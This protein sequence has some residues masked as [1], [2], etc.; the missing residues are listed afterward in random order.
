MLFRS[1][2]TYI[3]YP[4]HFIGK[5]KDLD[6]FLR[7]HEGLSFSGVLASLSPKLRKIKVYELFQVHGRALCGMPD[8]LYQHGFKNVSAMLLV[9]SQFDC[10]DYNSI[11][12]G[13]EK[14]FILRC[15]PRGPAFIVEHQPILAKFQFP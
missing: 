3:A 10:F 6:K 9:V 2:F 8:R 7:D 15:H 5:E 14:N 4:Y 11:D 13:M 12:E 1:D